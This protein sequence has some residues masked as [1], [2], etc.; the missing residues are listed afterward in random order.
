MYTLLGSLFML[1]AIVTV[2]KNEGTMDL[3]LLSQTGISLESQLYLWAGFTLAI[4]IKT[5]MAP[6]HM[7]LPRAH[8][9]SPLAGSLIL[10]GYNS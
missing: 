9:A 2:Y 1:L 8:A 6:F 7:W 3:M 4:A 5:P 10:A